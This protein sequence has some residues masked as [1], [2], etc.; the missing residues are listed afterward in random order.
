VAELRAAIVGCGPRAEAH[1]EAYAAGVRSGRLVACCDVDAARRERFAAR[2]G[3]REAFADLSA[4]L[5]QVRPDLLHVVTSPRFRPA[6]L[7]AVRR[8]RPRAVLVEKPLARTPGEAR[9]WVEGL[10]ALGIPLFVNHQLRFH[11]PFARV[12]ALLQEGAIGELAFGRA[13]C[14]GNLLEQGTHLF[15]LLSFCFDDVPAAWVFAQAEGA[16]GFAGDHPAPAYAAGV[17]VF[18]GDVHV[19][20]ECG[21]PAGTWRREP[22]YWLN[23]G[24]EFVGTR[25]RVGASTNH[26]W[27]LETWDGRREGEEV[28]YGEE[29]LRAEARLIESVLTSLDRPEAHPS[30]AEIACRS[31][32]LVMAVQRSALHRRRVDP[33]QATQDAELAAL[34]EALAGEEGAGA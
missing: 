8:G 19:A 30:R 4:M 23:K 29:D 10:A 22:N 17:V 18:P 16:E 21:A 28:P 5:E 20:F 25:G 26:G 31:F 34:R 7:E 13:S 12:R 33:R 2:F 15:D 11:G 3:I 14:R 6:V 32:D 9:E 27:W 1:A 24:L